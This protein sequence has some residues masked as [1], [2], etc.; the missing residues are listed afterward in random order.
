MLHGGFSLRSR[1]FEGSPAGGAT[2]STLAF[3]T[4]GCSITLDAWLGVGAVAGT[5]AFAT[6]AGSITLDAAGGGATGG[7][8]V[9]AAG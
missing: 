7:G 1:T 6:W 9:G 8:G 5:L 4:C 3:A 2:G